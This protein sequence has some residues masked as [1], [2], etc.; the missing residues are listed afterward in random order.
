MTL[1]LGKKTS[2]LTGESFN[3]WLFWSSTRSIKLSAFEKVFLRSYY[4]LKKRSKAVEENR[5]AFGH[6]RSIMTRFTAN[7]DAVDSH[8]QVMHAL[9]KYNRDK[10]KQTEITKTI[11]ANFCSLIADEITCGLIWNGPKKRNQQANRTQ[12]GGVVSDHVGEC[13]KSEKPTHGY[14]ATQNWND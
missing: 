7:A 3:D 13:N 2:I 5:L 12:Y 8:N 6:S 9:A 10:W 14:H 1:T 11:S 4:S